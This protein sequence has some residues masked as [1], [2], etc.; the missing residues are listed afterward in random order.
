MLHHAAQ[1]NVQSVHITLSKFVRKIKDGWCNS[2]LLCWT[3]KIRL[4]RLEQGESIRHTGLK[5]LA[6]LFEEQ[7][8]NGP[9][10]FA[11]AVLHLKDW[12]KNF[13]DSVLNHS[14]LSKSNV[15]VWHIYISSM[16]TYRCSSRSASVKHT[17]HIIPHF[18]SRLM[19]H[20]LT[21][22]CKIG[23]PFFPSK[24]DLSKRP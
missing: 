10:R 16:C 9:N 13:S 14:L 20:L 6:V 1:K 4:A 17:A 21:L 22:P 24:C 12:W 15:F 11:V 18:F 7:K 2:V 8:K 23:F 19:W 3:D 5:S